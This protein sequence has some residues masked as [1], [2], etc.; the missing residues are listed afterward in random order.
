MR[1]SLPVPRRLSALILFSSTSF[2][3]AG[4]STGSDEVAG[5][6]ASLEDASA[7]GCLS[8]DLALSEGLSSAGAA[9]ALTTPITSLLTMTSPESLTIFSSTP[10][11]G[12]TTSITTLSVSIST[13]SSSRLTA[14]PAF[15]YQLAIV[16]S[17]TDSG[18]CGALISIDMFFPYTYVICLFSVIT[19][20]G[21][22]CLQ[23]SWHHPGMP[24]VVAYAVP[25]SLPPVPPMA[26]GR[27]NADSRYRSM[28]GSLCAYDAGW[29]TRRPGSWVLPDTRRLL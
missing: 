16:P 9:P 28:S 1:P 2:L 14:S 18:N 13:S 6:A 12:D 15:L 21:I 22:T 3:A 10:S 7:A 11:V 17:G 24:A 27:R 25:D 23:K 20:C 8:S 19:S 26:H 5:T 4:L 29:S